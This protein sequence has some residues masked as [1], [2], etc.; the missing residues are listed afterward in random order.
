ML[1]LF[2]FLIL[3]NSFHCQCVVYVR[4]Y[5]KWKI[6]KTS[7]GIQSLTEFNGCYLFSKQNRQ[8]QNANNK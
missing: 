8:K 2:L 3:F 6:E 7:A 1:I 4:E 5:A